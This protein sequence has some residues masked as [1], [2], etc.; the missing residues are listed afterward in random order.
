MYT[1]QPF[2]APTT[3]IPY[4]ERDRNAKLKAAILFARVRSSIR[5]CTSLPQPLQPDA[6]KR[7]STELVKI[8][9]L[10]TVIQHFTPFD[11]HRPT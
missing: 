6:V 7:L 4:V 2:L 1:K 9:Y 11:C 3:L 8:I 10:S 5:A